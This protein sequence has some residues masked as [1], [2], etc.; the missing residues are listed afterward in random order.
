MNTKELL[1]KLENGEISDTDKEVLLK[2]FT[3]IIRE[4]NAVSKE[5]LNK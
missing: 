2:H 5:F 1:E 4:V 3:K